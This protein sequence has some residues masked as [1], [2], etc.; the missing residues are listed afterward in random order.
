MPPAPHAKSLPR[1]PSPGFG[2]F[3]SLLSPILPF[4]LAFLAVAFF[5]LIDP[6]KA[7]AQAPSGQTQSAKPPQAKPNE[8]SPG[9]GKQD[10][11]KP[12]VTWNESVKPK[13]IFDQAAK[14]HNFQLEIGPAIEAPKP[15]EEF[16]F[17]KE[18]LIIIG[19][20]IFAVA[21][22]LVLRSFLLAKKAA[23]KK[24]PEKEDKKEDEVDTQGLKDT[25]R[26]ADVL[27]SQGLFI[28]AMHT[29]LLDTIEDLKNQKNLIFP[30]SF[31]SREIVNNLRLGLGATQS[32]GEIVN[33]VEPT[34][35]GEDKPGLEQYQSLRQKYDNFIN[36]LSP[37]LA[38]QGSL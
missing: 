16:V 24:V 38:G 19:S 1:G 9:P 36:L 3:P 18:I 14:E 5:A 26:R 32:L 29:I 2:P 34:W 37:G 28:E 4:A 25:R 35:F 10:T 27:A 20:A 33:T 17:P 12:K 31:T 6:A 22:F 13:A 23:K 30:T 7:W 15:K 11:G 21:L 8:A